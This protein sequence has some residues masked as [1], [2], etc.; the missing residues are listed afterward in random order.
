MNGHEGPAIVSLFVDKVVVTVWQQD[1]FRPTRRGKFNFD[2]TS[3]RVRVLKPFINIAVRVIKVIV[4]V[5]CAASDNAE[6]HRH[7]HVLQTR[8]SVAAGE[9]AVSYNYV[10]SET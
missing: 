8:D 9:A 10:P 2:I 1:G 3:A 6:G 5:P 4:V 7:N